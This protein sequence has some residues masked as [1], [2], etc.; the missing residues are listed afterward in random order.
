M[1]NNE[2]SQVFWLENW[3]GK[4]M[5][6]VFTRCNLNTIIKDMNLKGSRVVGIKIDLDEKWNLELLLED[7][8]D[9]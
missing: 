6:G 9:G 5:T 4:A 8:S 7:D 1:T 2:S 3:E